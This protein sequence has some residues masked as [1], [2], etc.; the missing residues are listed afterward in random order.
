MHI[1]QIANGDFFS[2]YG[3]GQ[4][5]VKNLVDEM[6]RQQLAVSVFSFVNK[7]SR[8][9]FEKKNYKG[10]DLYEFYTKDIE[11]I[12]KTIEGINPDI[13][14]VHAEKS[15]FASIRKEL[16][17]FVLVV[18]AHH[19]G[20]TCPAGTLL[21]TK[22]EI[23]KIPV[24]HEDCLACV[25]RNSKG[26]L[27]FYKLFK[28]IP[29]SYRL[30]WGK[31]IRKL[32]FIYF[33][34]PWSISSL[35]IK[36]K[37]KDWGTIVDNVDCMIA[38]SNAIADNMILNGLP[39]ERIQVIPHGIPF[40]SHNSLAIRDNSHITK[41]FYVGRLG[42]IKGIHILLQA[43]TQLDP[44]KCELHL[45]GDISGKYEKNLVKKY[46]KHSN[47]IFYGK[48]NPDEV[49]SYI[50]QFDVLVHS[51]IC[52]EIFGLNIAEALSQSKPVIAT[53]CGGAE[54]QIQDKE[55]G[56]LIEPNNTEAIRKA[57]QCFI[58]NPNEIKRMSLNAP[59]NVISREEHVKRLVT[60]YND[61]I[62]ER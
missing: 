42:Y 2:T 61:L 47:I 13:I 24:S 16:D 60:R 49:L 20:I 58:D 52:L 17:S 5:Y 35:Q 46:R 11:I 8:V 45:I 36:N 21:N 12:K 34:T 14:H 18:T 29:L 37:M 10:I 6:I 44:S 56:L 23:C 15:L 53:R 57:M 26:G 39:C 38:P 54:M 3:G 30:K 25:L 28:H 55:N 43:F 40:S 19:G 1:L 9:P 59:V 22:D 27:D 7:S 50:Q 48:I 4:V 31:L 51:T 62:Y 32:P 41:F 33:L